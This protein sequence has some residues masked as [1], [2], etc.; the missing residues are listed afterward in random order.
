MVSV[1]VEKAALQENFRNVKSMLYPFHL[2][3]IWCGYPRPCHM[4]WRH[5]TRAE[6]WLCHVALNARCSTALRPQ[7]TQ[8]GVTHSL[9]HT[10]DIIH[11]E[12]DKLKPIFEHHIDG[13]LSRG[14][15]RKHMPRIWLTY[16]RWYWSQSIHSQQRLR[17]QLPLERV[18]HYC[19]KP[20]TKGIMF[21]VI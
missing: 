6:I 8:T 16:G 4:T 20:T 11:R 7:R 10:K 19:D 1:I 5:N 12:W 13:I 3:L 18:C 14:D 17:P 21:T 9:T 2:N 15:G